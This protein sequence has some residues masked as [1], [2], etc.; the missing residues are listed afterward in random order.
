MPA[1]LGAWVADAVGAEQAGEHFA[2]VTA[3]PAEAQD[4][5]IDADAVFA[6]WDWVGGR[7]SLGSAVGLSLMIAVGPLCLRR[8]AGWNA[9]HR[10]ALPHRSLE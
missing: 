5:G 4:F 3:N 8:H 2:A 6:M 10:R 7:Y 9:P 1:P